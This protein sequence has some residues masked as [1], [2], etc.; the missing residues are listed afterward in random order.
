VDGDPAERT[1]HHQAVAVL[2]SGKLTKEDYLVDELNRILDRH[3]VQGLVLIQVIDDGR[4]GR[5]FGL[6]RVGLSIS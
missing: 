6:V 3:D 1:E 5:G 4:E 2:V